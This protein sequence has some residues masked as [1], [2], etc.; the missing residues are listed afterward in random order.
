[1]PEAPSGN[2]PAIRRALIGISIAA[3]AC[4]VVLL[5]LM[6][7]V[8]P[9]SRDAL[10]H[11][12]AIPKLFL[13]H[14]ILAEFPDIPFS[15]YPMNLDLLY[16]LPLALGSDIAAKYIHLVFGLLT[17]GV[18]FQYLRK[19][20]NSIWGLAGSLLWLSIPVV[21]R[22]STEV[23]VD[24]GLAFFSTAAMYAVLRWAETDG[25]SRLLVLAG[26]WCG[27]ALGT[28]YNALLVLAILVL[29]LPFVYFR[30]RSLRDSTVADLKPGPAGQ[31]PPAH[32][33]R[34]DRDTIVGAM[35]SGVI[36]S[37]VALTV[38]SPWMIRNAYLKG[39]PL[40]PMLNR[41]FQSD[42]AVDRDDWS[43]T[44][45]MVQD[46][47]NTLTVR[48]LVF[49]ESPGYIALV[50]L[51]V[52]YEGRDDDPRYFDGKLNPFLL[53]FML[54][55]L[56]LGRFPPRRLAIECRIWFAFAAL[57]MLMAFFLAPIRIRYLLPIL[58]AIC[59]LAVIGIYNLV[60][61]LQL[62][63]NPQGR[64]TSL[65]LLAVTV[66]LAF[67]YN[68]VYIAERF[69]RVAPLEYIRGQVS[70]TDYITQHRPEYPLIQS[71]NATVDADARILALFLGQR[72]YYFD[73]EVVFNEGWLVKAVKDATSH[74]AI[75]HRLVA[76]GITHIMVR[77][78]LFQ[79]WL[80]MVLTP[81]EIGRLSR[82]WHLQLK[83]IKNSNGFLL[84]AIE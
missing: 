77:G 22:L 72:R 26:G 27:L 8:P 19:R 42:G 5:V 45:T 21:V 35:A 32:S 41:L 34:F 80:P 54:P 23:Y 53:V 61:R 6:A 31:P 2:R 67:G 18:I 48:R 40:Y 37:A 25:R 52:F 1:M 17:A 16:L 57:F 66:V 15:Y 73:R 55:A 13:Q 49:K 24:L 59:I 46:T 4:L 64:L 68:A 39:N 20:T 38:F 60:N 81:D 83:M 78:D 56:V 3:L 79:Q 7:S 84:Y 47:S 69:V 62:I 71:A 76:Q 82:F 44:A 28:K 9:V 63:A 75:K 33:R 43:R 51:R 14:G 29:L 50:P 58:P 11:H 70:R 30:L 12:L 74:E 65:A 10:T 36:F